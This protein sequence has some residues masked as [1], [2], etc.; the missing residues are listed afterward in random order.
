MAEEQKRDF[1]GELPEGVRKLQDDF[2]EIC[3]SFYRVF[4]KILIDRDNE[5]RSLKE[6]SREKDSRLAAQTDF[7]S[8]AARAL[9]RAKEDS[10]RHEGNCVAQILRLSEISRGRLLKTIGIGINTDL[11][12]GIDGAYFLKYISIALEPRLILDALCRILRVSE[13]DFFGML[14][15][16]MAKR[17]SEAKESG[18]GVTYYE[19]FSDI[20]GELRAKSCCQKGECGTCGC[21]EKKDG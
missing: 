13:D 18:R 20:G 10:A 19:D 15:G 17:F 21:E 5:I 1:F 6:Q 16:D 11:Y 14:D 7:V 9:E 3:H 4:M 12:K 2:W 8:E